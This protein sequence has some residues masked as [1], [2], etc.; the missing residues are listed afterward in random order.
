MPVLIVQFPHYAKEHLTDNN[1]ASY[2][3]FKNDFIRSG[4]LPWND[5]IHRRKFFNINGSYVDGSNQLHENEKVFFWGEWEAPSSFTSNFPA[6]PYPPFIHHLLHA[7]D[8]GSYINN[9][10]VIVPNMPPGFTHA[11]KS[12]LQN[13][14]PYVFGK[15]FIY[16]NCKQKGKLKV[17]A[18]GSVILFGS[19]VD[20]K[21]V[22]DTVFVVSDSINYTLD[23]E[24]SFFDGLIADG[25][26]SR[27]FY[28]VTIKALQQDPAIANHNNLLTLYKG[29]TYGKPVD[30]MYSFFPCSNKAR[31]NR[32][33]L[34]GLGI[35]PKLTRGTKY[36]K[37]LSKKAWTEV[38]RQVSKQNLMLGVFAEEPPVQ[39]P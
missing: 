17:L 18:P 21:F 25:W 15:H 32:P 23:K 1:G 29:A 20:K 14:D 13:T 8:P 12:G 6:K 16:S 28:N 7:H 11:S 10:N 26:I 30:R 39:I 3:Q 35:N 37:I 24:E 33:E 4:Y 22:L 19:S 5:G 2:V 38:V 9:S 31:F 34:T 36:I 27:T